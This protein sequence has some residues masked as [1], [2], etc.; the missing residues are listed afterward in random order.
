MLLTNS[1]RAQVLELTDFPTGGLLGTSGEVDNASVITINQTTAGQTLVIPSPAQTGVAYRL[2]LVNIGGESFDIES[3]TATSNLPLGITLGVNG[4]VNLI[5]IGLVWR[6][7]AN[8][9]GPKK[10]FVQQALTAGSNFITHNLGLAV[11]AAVIISV[12]DDTYGQVIEVNPGVGSGS[13]S[14][15]YTANNLAFNILAPVTLANI[16][17]IG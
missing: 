17:I 3:Q 6:K 5:S 1:L 16:T 13:A 4:S 11:P 9:S 8:T 2:T 7:A 15:R 14:N 12:I 10:F